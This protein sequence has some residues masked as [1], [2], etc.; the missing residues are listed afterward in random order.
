MPHAF[1][2]ARTVFCLE[3]KLPLS[4]RSARDLVMH[5]AARLYC[6]IRMCVV[7]IKIKYL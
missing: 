6:G 2:E 3:I 7:V 5:T 1:T 4:K